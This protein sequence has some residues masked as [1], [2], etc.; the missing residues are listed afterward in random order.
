MPFVAKASI[1]T[2]YEK[3]DGEVTRLQRDVLRIRWKDKVG[4]DLYIYKNHDRIASVNLLQVLLALKNLKF[5]G[6]IFKEYFRIYGQS[7]KFIDFDFRTAYITPWSSLF[8]CLAMYR[9]LDPQNLFHSN[10]TLALMAFLYAFYML[11]I[12][13]VL[14]DAYQIF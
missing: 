11:F 6:P 8:T 9:I 3:I 12:E 1:Y 13:D 14:R 4:G 5:F 7:L 2:V 10:D